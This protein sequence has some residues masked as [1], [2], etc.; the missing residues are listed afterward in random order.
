MASKTETPEAGKEILSYCTKCK[1]DLAHTIV[2][3][4]GDR[5]VKVECKTCNGTHQ[6]RAPKGVTER[7]PKKARI[8]KEA[9]LSVSIEGEWQRL[10]D[11]HQNKPFKKY[12]MQS[13]FQ[14]GDKINHGKFGDGIISK[15]IYPNKI[16]IIF[17]NEIKLLIH[18]GIKV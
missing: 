15:V 18:A 17:K 9:A 10:M 16:E 1:I 11:T 6:Y 5:V 2:A 12:S 14:L 8:S 7:A 13:N 3:M 4:S